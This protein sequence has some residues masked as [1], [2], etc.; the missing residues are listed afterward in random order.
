MDWVRYQN[1]RAD[2]FEE[3]DRR[4]LAGFFVRV[5]KITRLTPGAPSLKTVILEYKNREMKQK[6]EKQWITIKII[7]LKSSS[8]CRCFHEDTH[9]QKQNYIYPSE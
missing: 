8:L 9:K 2:Y 3:G 7:F 5:Y 4:S 6:E 1:N